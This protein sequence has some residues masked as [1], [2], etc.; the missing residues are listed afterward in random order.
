MKLLN[1]LKLLKHRNPG[2]LQSE[3]SYWESNKLTMYQ[4]NSYPRVP[5]RIWP[6]HAHEGSSSLRYDLALSCHS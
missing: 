2:N 3:A 5:S 6:G 4:I 1:L